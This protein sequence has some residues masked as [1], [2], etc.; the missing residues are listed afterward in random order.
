[1][2]NPTSLFR[3]FRADSR[4]VDN[5]TPVQLLSAKA[6]G[7][8]LPTSLLGLSANAAPLSDG[9]SFFKHTLHLLQATTSIAGT[10]L[11]GA[12]YQFTINVPE[13]AGEPDSYYWPR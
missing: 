1:M 6:L 2:L 8:L 11:P 3:R 5:L 7:L 13:K 12:T 10:V 9:Q 4:R